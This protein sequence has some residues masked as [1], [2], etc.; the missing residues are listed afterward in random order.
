M[1]TTIVHYSLFVAQHLTCLFFLLFVVADERFLTASISKDSKS[2]RN[3]VKRENIPSDFFF[4][5]FIFV[6]YFFI[7]F[8]KNTNFVTSLR[9]FNKF[10][11][12]GLQYLQ[13]YYNHNNNN[14]IFGS[15]FSCDYEQM[16][17]YWLCPTFNSYSFGSE[18]W[19]KI[20]IF[21]N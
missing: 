17:V 14:I 19:L 5:S 11:N 6:S 15:E 13:L 9:S 8:I 21:L 16:A 1:V 20:L 3:E 2:V 10:L 7:C 12:H 4:Y 18:L